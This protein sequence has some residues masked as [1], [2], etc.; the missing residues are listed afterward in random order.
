MSRSNG[1]ELPSGWFE[2]R[3]GDLAEGSRH[4]VDPRR[5]PDEEFELY[6]IPAHPTGVP[7]AV[8][9]NEIGSAKQRVTP[10]TVL[11]GR[12]NPRINRV[13]VVRARARSH[14]I[15]STEWVAFPP[16]AEVD[17]D[18]LAYYL[19]R[20]DV[21]DFLASNASGVGGSLMRVKSS[22]LADYPF[23]RP[24]A[25]EQRAIVEVLDSYFS[26]LESSQNA[27]ARVRRNL[28]RFRGS[29]LKAAVDGRLVPTEAELARSQRRAYEPAST[30]LVRI[31][32]ERRRTWEMLGRTGQYREPIEPDVSAFTALPEGWCWATIDQLTSE[33]RYGSSAKTDNDLTGVPVLRMPNIVDGSLD[34]SKLKYLPHTHS[35]FPDLL[36]RP[37]DIL[38]NRTNSADLV[39][40]T[41][42]F[43]GIPRICSYASYLIRLRPLDGASA[44]MMASFLNSTAGRQWA[45]SVASQQVGQANINGS[46]L[47]ALAIPVPPEA[48]AIR[49]AVEAERLFSIVETQRD[50]AA[51]ADRR[52]RGL[53]DGILALAFAGR[54]VNTAGAGIASPA[55][56][57]C[58]DTLVKRSR[59]RRSVAE[60]G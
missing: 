45:A 50:V 18:F 59:G 34:L 30:L 55:A 43:R 6:S 29:I 41:A 17:P 19:R 23:P 56:A 22:T 7:E 53:R 38:F 51:A 39:G 32:A 3:L 58:S 12:I 49:I 37:G 15:A 47:K 57:Q 25:T 8:R 40:K 33:V 21:R 20:N 14:Q 35:E 10:G 1:S 24:P 13:W 26:Q 48:E 44:F 52:S 5:H 9:G 2:T 46:K 60:R 36:L 31:L 16:S 54:L 4:T 27:L 11:L 42:V 28:E